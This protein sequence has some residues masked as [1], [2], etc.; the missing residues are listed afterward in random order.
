MGS[1]HFSQKQ[2]LTILQSAEEVGIKEAAN[3]AGIHF[4]TVYDWKKQLESHGEKGFLEYKPSYPGR[5]CKEITVEQEKHVLECWERN[6]AYGPGQV[7]SQLRRQG[8][9]ISTKTVRKIMK[10][11]GYEFAHKKDKEEEGTRYEASRPL[12]LVQMDILEFYINKAKIYVLILLDDYSRFILGFRLLDETS[13][14]DVI[15]LVSESINRYG[16]MEEVLTDR[17]FVFYSWR[18]INR[19]EK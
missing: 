17:G 5:G 18:G 13:T 15:D 14:E 11:S 12:E 4:T 16:K 8:I 19:F 3:L 9:T 7:R 10:A 2:K 1:K 6:P